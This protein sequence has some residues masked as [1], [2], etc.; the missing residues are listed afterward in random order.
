MK[1]FYNVSVT[2]RKVKKSSLENYVI[3]AHLELIP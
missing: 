1:P 3:V 2:C